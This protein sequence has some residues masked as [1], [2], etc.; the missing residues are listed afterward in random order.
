MYM[1]Y[2]CYYLMQNDFGFLLFLED[3]WSGEGSIQEYNKK[4]GGNEALL[5]PTSTFGNWNF[6]KKI[7]STQTS[8]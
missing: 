6:E 7:K 4:T 2:T 8:L 1:A 5:R 3:S